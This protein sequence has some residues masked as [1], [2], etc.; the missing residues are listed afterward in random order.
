MATIVDSAAGLKYRAI[1]FPLLLSTTTV[2]PAVQAD[3]EVFE[4]KVGSREAQSDELPELD[5]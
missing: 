4:I 1:P 2:V 5:L 3:S